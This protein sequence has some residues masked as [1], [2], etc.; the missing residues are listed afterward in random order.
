[1]ELVALEYRE[2][3][4]H[5]L[6]PKRLHVRPRNAGGVDRAVQDAKRVWIY[7]SHSIWSK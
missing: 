7:A 6:A 3:R 1:V 4:V 5:A 2:L